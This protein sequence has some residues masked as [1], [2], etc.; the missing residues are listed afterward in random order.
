MQNPLQAA[1]ISEV[2]AGKDGIKIKQHSPLQAMKML[3]DMQGFNAPMKTEQSGTIATV[4]MSKEEYA[5]T[6]RKM[7]EEDDC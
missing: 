7:M 2:T 1:S 5:E 6:R 3:S 4:Q